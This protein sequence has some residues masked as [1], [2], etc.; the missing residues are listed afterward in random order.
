MV[1]E[2]P[3]IECFNENSELGTEDVKIQGLSWM[4]FD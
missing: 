3:K 4:S 1:A 2:L